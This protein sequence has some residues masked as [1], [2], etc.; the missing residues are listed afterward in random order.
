MDASAYAH[1]DAPWKTAVVTSDFSRKRI[2]VRQSSARTIS[3]PSRTD[4][5]SASITDGGIL[6][7]HFLPAR[8]ELV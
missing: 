5:L 4:S 1:D 3:E 2:K 8:I 7:V 6:A